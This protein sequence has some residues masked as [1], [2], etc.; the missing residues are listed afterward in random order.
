MQE[1]K[2]DGSKG[3]PTHFD[4]DAMKEMLKDPEVKEVRVFSKPRKILVVGDDGDS[5]KSRLN[6]RKEMAKAPMQSP[7][8]DQRQID[9]GK[10]ESKPRAPKIIPNFML[11]PGMKINL[12][13]T[14]YKVI[15]SRPNGKVTMKFVRFIEEHERSNA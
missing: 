13:G 4:E 6:L 3:P 11:K 7:P 15:A 10:K 12:H 2:H 9:P 14:L 5:E 1:V 8:D